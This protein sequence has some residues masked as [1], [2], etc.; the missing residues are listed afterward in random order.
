MLEIDK[1]SYCYK[2]GQ[3]AVREA[4]LKVA[5]GEFVAVAGRNG[6]GKTTLTRLVMGLLQPAAG[7]IMLDGRC[8]AGRPTAE[9]ARQIGYVFQNPDRQIFRD[10]VAEEVAYGPEQLGYDAEAAR[11]AVAKALVATDLAAVAGAYPRSLSKGQKQRLAIASAL[12]LEPRLLIL[13]EPT[14]GQD[15]REK[16]ALMALLVGLNAKG[17]AILLVTHDM[18]L[19]ARYAHRAVVLAGGRVVYDGGVRA[20]FAGGAAVE[21]WGLREPATAKVARGLKPFGFATEAVTPEEL[22]GAICVA[23]GKTYA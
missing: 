12:A 15:A 9:L 3:Y 8:T 1:V 22:S 16:A 7:R 2:P 4:S 14:S 11:A 6:S 10:T 23:G 19:L 20:L 13:D 17:T 5:G 21:D 18:E